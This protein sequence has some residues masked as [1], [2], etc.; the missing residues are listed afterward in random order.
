MWIKYRHKWSSG[1]DKEWEWK[2]LGPIPAR[3]DLKQVEREAAREINES[4]YQDSEHYRGI[5][6][7][8]V[9]IPPRGVIEAH[10]KEARDSARRWAARARGLAAL[11]KSIP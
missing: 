5:D 4:A 1:V 6:C 7:E 8:L 10:L 9:D 11:L 3:A 2:D